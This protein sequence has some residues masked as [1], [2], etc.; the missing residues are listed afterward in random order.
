MTS[1]A[2]LNECNHA[3]NPARALLEEL[4]WTNAPREALAE[5][6]DDEREV[7]LKGRMGWDRSNCVGEHCNHDILDTVVD[8]AQSA[9]AFLLWQTAPRCG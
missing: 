1:P 4:G 3:E 2:K 9:L 6:R 8:C 5:E 7:L